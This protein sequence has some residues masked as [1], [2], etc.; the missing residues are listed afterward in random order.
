[1]IRD[2]ISEV[3]GEYRRLM[4]ER[5]QGRTPMRDWKALIKPWVSIYTL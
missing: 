2:R 4:E 3:R 1:M 5:G